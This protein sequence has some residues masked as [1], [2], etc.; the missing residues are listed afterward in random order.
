MR[1]I[2]IGLLFAFFSGCSHTNNISPKDKQQVLNNY[3]LK[4]V[5]LTQRNKRRNN[6]IALIPENIA[7]VYKNVN[8]NYFGFGS[9]G[10]INIEPCARGNCNKATRQRVANTNSYKN[11]LK[12][13]NCKQYRKKIDTTYHGR[14]AQIL[15]CNNPK[16]PYEKSYEQLY[17]N[18]IRAILK[19]EQATYSCAG[20]WIM[21]WQNSC[22]INL[23]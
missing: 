17:T 12:M 13:L 19:K 18:N 5:D 16:H 20:W 22:L 6:N 8:G 9:T 3:L 7:V 15:F 23:K 2:I 21:D 1:Y 4:R 11:V 10:N 14:K